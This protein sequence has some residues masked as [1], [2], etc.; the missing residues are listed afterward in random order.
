MCRFKLS[1]DFVVNADE[2]GEVVEYDDDTKIMIVRYKS[3]KKFFYKATMSKS[4]MAFDTLKTVA[5]NFFDGSFSKMSHFIEV[6][7]GEVV[8]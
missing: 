8:Y 1:S 7:C 5:E 4:E 6:E 3:G 2:D